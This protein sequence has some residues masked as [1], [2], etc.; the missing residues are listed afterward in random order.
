[1]ILPLG[2]IS[3]MLIGGLRVLDVVGLLAAALTSRCKGYGKELGI[4][5][6]TRGY[7]FRI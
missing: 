2:I 5:A 4:H 1:M 6:R 3:M 7:L